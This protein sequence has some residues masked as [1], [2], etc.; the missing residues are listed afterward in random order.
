M[1]KPSFWWISI[2]VIALD[3]ITKIVVRKFIVLHDT[4]K[5]TPKFF[6]LTHV[7]NEGAAFSLSFGNPIVNRIIFI[8]VSIIA[9]ILILRLKIKSTSKTEQII[10]TLVLGGAIGNL[11][12]RV[13]FGSVTDFI[14]WDFPDFIMQRWPVFNIADSSIVIAI[15]LIVITSIFQ[16]KN[17][18]EDK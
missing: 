17:I 8:M 15:S 3:Q 14:W 6:W 5:I 7:E 11:I 18:L 1:R 16:K 4:I 9:A 2:L 13:I 12:D 10:Y